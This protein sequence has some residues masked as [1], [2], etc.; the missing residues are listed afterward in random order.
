[1]C[2][3]FVRLPRRNRLRRGLNPPILDTACRRRAPESL[4]SWKVMRGFFNHLSEMLNLRPPPPRKAECGF[5]GGV[6]CIGACGA[7]QTPDRTISLS[8]RIVLEDGCGRIECPDGAALLFGRHSPEEKAILQKCAD[9]DRC[10]I[11][12]RVE[13]GRLQGVVSVERG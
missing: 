12:A 10:T 11:T 5:C 8:G 4:P 6:R 3:A 1:M 2:P 7:Q 13:N 9:G